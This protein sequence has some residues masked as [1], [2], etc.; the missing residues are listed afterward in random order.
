MSPNVH[1]IARIGHGGMAEVFLAASTSAGVSKLVVLKRIWPELAANP[2]FLAMFLDEARLSARMNHPNIVQVYDVCGDRE[3][4]TITMEYLHGQSLSSLVRR[5]GGP[6]GLPLVVRL[7]IVLDVLAGLD[8]AHRLTNY[9]GTP[10]GV[11]HRD[12]SPQNVLITYDGHVKLVDFGIAKSLAVPSGSRIG[13]VAGKPAYMAP[14]AFQGRTV[15][16]RADIFSVGVIL[17]ELLDGR[18]LWPAGDQGTIVRRLSAGLTLPDLRSDVDVS[19]GL[20]AVCRRALAVDPS[21]RFSSAAA[22]EAALERAAAEL[23][24][25][26]TRQ[27]AAIMSS[28]FAGERAARERQIERHVEN[29]MPDAGDGE[30]EGRMDD[31]ADEQTRVRFDEPPP[32]PP[33]PALVA[34]PPRSR[35]ILGGWR[36]VAPACVGAF[37]IAAVSMMSWRQD[38]PAAGQVVAAQDNRRSPAKP[39]L[40]PVPLSPE[41]T[42]VTPRGDSGEAVSVVAGDLVDDLADAGRKA[43]RRRSTTRRRRAENDPLFALSEVAS[44]RREVTMGERDRRG[45]NEVGAIPRPVRRR[46]IDTANPFSP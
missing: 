9:D 14:D 37:T 27:L 7:R 41:T 13:H 25:S 30:G 32:A 17:W 38:G 6:W 11:V 23:A 46:T 28:V 29:D 10:L 44:A 18:R 15:D 16:H 12:V 34:T 31:D 24:G 43:R 39:I 40:I 26:P 5:V 42:P 33:P 45:V 8:Y 19:D 1:P 3:R 21:D 35:A 20:R 4:P 36:W 2:D 22:M